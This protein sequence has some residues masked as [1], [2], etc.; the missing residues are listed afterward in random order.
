MS[1]IAPHSITDW[2]TVIGS[3]GTV[4][5]GAGWIV[6][7]AFKH[8]IHEQ[9]VELR[10]NGGGSTYDQVRKAAKD[11]ERAAFAA[12]RAVDSALELHGHITEISNRV[13]SLEQ[14]IVKQI[15][16]DN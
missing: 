7:R 10:P 6:S 15:N 11:A 9:L 2:A 8:W 13:S 3:V 4:V 5:A 1:S 14:I 12:E 16:K